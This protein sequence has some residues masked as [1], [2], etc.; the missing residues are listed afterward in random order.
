V[1]GDIMA[2]EGIIHLVDRVLIPAELMAEIDAAPMPDK[3]AG[4]PASKPANP[5]VAGAAPDETGS[6]EQQ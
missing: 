5:E 3:I 4:A 1:R 6:I 2:S